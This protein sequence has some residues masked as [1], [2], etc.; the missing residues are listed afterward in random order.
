M[1]Q[2]H[3][4]RITSGFITKSN[5]ANVSRSRAVPYDSEIALLF[6][7]N[8][9]TTTFTDSS[10]KV[11]VITTN[12]NSTTSNT[13]TKFG[14]VLAIDGT[15]DYL[16]WPAN[17]DFELASGDHTT[18]CWIYKTSSVTSTI[19]SIS[20]STGSGGYAGNQFAIRDD[21]SAI[22]L[23]G[24]SASAWINTSNVAV[25]GTF[26]NNV[27]T[28]IAC[29]RQGSDFSVYKDGRRVG[30]YTSTTAIGTING[31]NYL[32]AR[33]NGATIGEFNWPGYLTNFRLT[34]APIY[35]S[36]FTPN[37]DALSASGFFPKIEATILLKMDEAEGATDWADSSVNAVDFVTIGNTTTGGNLISSNAQSK[38]GTTS[39]LSTG[40]NGFGNG[41]IR[42]GYISDF[43]IVQ[44]SRDWTMEGWFYFL[45]LPSSSAY[46]SEIISLNGNT[47]GSAAALRITIWNN[48]AIR[49]LCA[50]S[51]GGWID[52]TFSS[53]NAVVLNTWHHIAACRE[54][55]SG[56]PNYRIYVDGVQKRVYS[57]ASAA[58]TIQGNLVVCGWELTSPQNTFNGYVDGV[59]WIN[60]ACLYPAGTTFTPPTEL[61]GNTVA[62]VSRVISNNTYGLRKNY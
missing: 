36:N 50:N 33:R 44:L 51:S 61:F 20:N 53:A 59:R 7:G 19:W 18:E 58:T 24:S 52:T 48:G 57:S 12:G 35:T 21:G 27:W 5:I 25:A 32:A 3:S 14:N 46:A 42:T 23:C 8:V 30:G 45:S 54:N 9:G 11:R 31:V 1:S 40:T 28:H 41:V 47:T 22:W 26:Q 55:V 62:S 6:N 34:K 15:G 10:P 39:L 4:T 37:T 29:V 13:Q 43:N 17:A 60:G 2:V 56:T 38:W 49:I 16:T